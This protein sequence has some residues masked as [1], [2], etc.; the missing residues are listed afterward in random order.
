MSQQ[1]IKQAGEVSAAN[2]QKL[3]SKV[4]AAEQARAEAEAI[5]AA[6]ESR[7]R[8][9]AA[10]YCS[11]LSRISETFRSL[12]SSSHPFDVCFKFEAEGVDIWESSSFLSSKSGYFKDLF[13]S[14]FAETTKE[15]REVD[16]CNQPTHLVRISD[17]S[18]QAFQAIFTWLRT[19]QMQFD[20]LGTASTL[21]AHDSQNG[22][23]SAASIYLL[24]HYLQLSQL[25]EITLDRVDNYLTPRNVFVELAR[26]WRGKPTE[27][28]DKLLAYAVANWNEVKKS[29]NLAPML[30]EVAENPERGAA[31]LELMR[32]VIG[33]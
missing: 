13:E 25:V 2:L 12:R 22:A 14:G 10:E 19:G 11:G 20:W 9:E 18:S 17:E 24:A 32:L 26:D 5:A 31:F 29:D 3:R 7:R 30:T 15:A 16:R 28:K 21:T 27:M 6:S 1:A 4:T 8:S 23:T 33:L